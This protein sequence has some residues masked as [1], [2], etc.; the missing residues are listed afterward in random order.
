MLER[1]RQFRAKANRL[2]QGRRVNRDFKEG[3]IV[4][5]WDMQR[6]GNLGDK[7]RP[8]WV[9]PCTLGERISRGIWRVVFPRGAQRVYHSDHLRPFKK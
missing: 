3:D 5:A 2:T 4:W 1:M 7:L 8:W 6:E 9:G